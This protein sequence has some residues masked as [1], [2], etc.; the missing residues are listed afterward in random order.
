M[1]RLLGFD[2][3]AAVAEISVDA[4]AAANKLD[5]KPKSDSEFNVQKLVDMF[6]KLNPLA[7]EFIPSKH[8]HH[9]DHLQQSYHQLSPNNFLVNTKPSADDNYPN[10]RRVLLFLSDLVFRDFFFLSMLFFA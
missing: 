8:F 7:K 10:N 9:H 6:T 2:S 5:S 3:M 4:A 1:F